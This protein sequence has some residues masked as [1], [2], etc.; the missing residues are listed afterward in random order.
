[1]SLF[2]KVLEEIDSPYNG[3]IRVVSNLEGV[4]ILVGG[5]SQSGWL[6]RKIWQA[7]IRRIAKEKESVGRVLV[8]GLGGGSV[9][10]LV[11][12]QW[13]KS[14]KVGIDI[15]GTMV[16][17]GKKYL[18]LGEVQNLK[19]EILDARKWLRDNKNK[20][21]DLVLVDIY[22]GEDIPQEFRKE[23]FIRDVLRVLKKDGIAAF[24]HL[25][26][27]RERRGANE[28]SQKLHHV[29]P[30]VTVVTPEAN[31]IFLCRS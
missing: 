22:K 5:I 23:G 27:A 19:A 6:V 29:F 9:A 13:P 10:E 28:F 25:Y 12:R 7:A 11:Q 1:M 30:S 4:R 16:E 26:S 17:L 14:K 2:F 20:K 21:F 8:L 15:D 18:G 3:N 24:N 31:I